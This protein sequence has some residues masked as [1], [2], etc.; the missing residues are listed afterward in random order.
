[1]EMNTQTRVVQTRVSFQASTL[2]P[3]DI[4]TFSKVAVNLRAY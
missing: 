1:M 2:S 3:E 4:Y